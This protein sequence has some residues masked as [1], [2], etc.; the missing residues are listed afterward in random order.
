MF[1]LLELLGRFESRPTTSQ[2]IGVIVRTGAA[3]AG[4]AGRRANVVAKRVVHRT[5]TPKRLAGREAFLRMV[6]V[7]D[8]RVTPG[9][10]FTLAFHWPDPGPRPR[11]GRCPLVS[12]GAYGVGHI[13]KEGR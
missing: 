5:D 7:R 11:H 8:S 4:L 6:V 12:L 9:V 13:R 10:A 1:G 2:F 3:S